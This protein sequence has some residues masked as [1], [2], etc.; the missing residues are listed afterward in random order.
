MDQALDESFFEIL[1]EQTGV[2]PEV[3]KKK[4]GGKVSTE[5]V[6]SSKKSRE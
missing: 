1:C 2:D 5:R 6:K 3:F 4:H